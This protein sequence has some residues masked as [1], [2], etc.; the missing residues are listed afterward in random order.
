MFGEMSRIRC[1]AWN[2]MKEKNEKQK[3]FL[4]PDV[5]L[6]FLINPDETGRKLLAPNETYGLVISD[7]GLYEALMCVEPNEKVAWDNLVLLMRNSDFLFTGK[8][9]NMTDDSRKHLRRIAL[10]KV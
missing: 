8:G 5:I 7:F 10:E 4:A 1:G 3:A 2:K 9:I 6:R